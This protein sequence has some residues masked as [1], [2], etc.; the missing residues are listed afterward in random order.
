M[1]ARLVRL[2]PYL[3]V[4]LGVAAALWAVSKDRHQVADTLS[5]LG[6]WATVLSIFWGLLAVFTTCLMWQQLLAGLGAPAPFAESARVFFISQLG[7]YLPGSVWPVLAQMEYGHRTNTGR[8]T[9]LAANAL[10]VA[11]NLAVGLIIAAGLLPFA[12]SDALHRY[13][14][15]FACLPLL[16]A[17]LHPKAVPGLLNLVF[18]RLGRARMESQLSWPTIFRATGWAILSW[19]FFGLHLLALVNGVGIHGWHVFAAATGGFALA[20]CAGILFIPAPAGAGIRDAVLIASLAAL[21][22]SGTALAIG[23]VSRVLLIVVDL[24]L[25]AGFG[26][27]GRRGRQFGAANTTMLSR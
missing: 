8:K 9:M 2:A 26:L 19:A 7:K 16:L 22:D 12:S 11:L 24:L 27:T 13:W 5:R 17:L 4:A 20:A 23:L 14:P 6:A 1:K 21:T 10:T 18:S 15:A 3:F 25:A